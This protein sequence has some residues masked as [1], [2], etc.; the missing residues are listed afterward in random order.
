MEDKIYHIYFIYQLGKAPMTA[1]I[2]LINQ[3]RLEWVQASNLARVLNRGT[4]CLHRGHERVLPRWFIGP[5]ALGPD[6]DA[7]G[8]NLNNNRSVRGRS[9]FLKIFGLRI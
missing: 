3:L 5:P 6:L 9:Y 2:G 7:Q 8:L 4:T 1:S